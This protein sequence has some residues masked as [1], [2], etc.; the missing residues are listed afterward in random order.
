MT[1]D[2][3]NAS[4]V[5]IEFQIF[6]MR[7]FLIILRVWST[8]VIS[9]TKAS[10]YRNGRLL[11]WTTWDDVNFFFWIVSTYPTAVIPREVLSR[12]YFS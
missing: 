4:W 8:L 5:L 12:L 11:L 6:L 9:S 3:D 10:A 2:L 1:K 7:Q